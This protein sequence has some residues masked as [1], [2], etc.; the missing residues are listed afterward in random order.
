[1]WKVL[2]KVVCEVGGAGLV[3]G[4]VG[5][6]VCKPVLLTKNVPKLHRHREGTHTLSDLIDSVVKLLGGF[7]PPVAETHN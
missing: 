3:L 5:Q 2:Q 7:I 6:P 4:N 1:M